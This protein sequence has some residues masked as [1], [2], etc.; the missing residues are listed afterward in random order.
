MTPIR[1][2]RGFTLVE[3][4]IGASLSAAIMAAVLSSYIYLGRNLGRLANQQSLESEGRRALGHFSQDVQS[5]T[6]LVTITSAPES[7]S[8]SRIDLTVPSGTG[9]NTITYYYNSGAS[10]T[11]VTVNSVT[12]SMAPGALTRCTATGASVSSQVLLRNIAGSGLTIRYYDGA[13]N[14]YSD[15]VAGIKQVALQFDTQLGNPAAGTL[16]PLYKVASSRLVLR[17]RTLLQ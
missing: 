8:A 13:G 14:E 17:N 12:V 10:P 3:L 1:S 6:G 9:T 4:L 11:N 5:A 7:P 15:Y 2:Q 16:T